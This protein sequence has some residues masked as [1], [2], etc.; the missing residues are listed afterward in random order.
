MWSQDQNSNRLKVLPILAEVSVISIIIVALADYLWKNA[1]LN[2]LDFN[3]QVAL[4]GLF[5]LLAIFAAN[6]IINRRW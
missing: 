3:L 1:G 6:Y 4:I 2:A 5:A